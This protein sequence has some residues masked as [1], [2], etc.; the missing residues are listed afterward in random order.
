M[1]TQNKKKLSGTSTHIVWTNF[2]TEA[3]KNEGC[4]RYKVQTVAF[5]KKQGMENTLALPILKMLYIYLLCPHSE[6]PNNPF[7]SKRSKQYHQRKR[8]NAKKLILIR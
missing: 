3:I 6:H 2:Y 4:Y 8:S 7:H 5:G 1:K